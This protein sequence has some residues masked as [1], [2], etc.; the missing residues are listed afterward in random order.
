MTQSHGS[1]LERKYFDGLN[2]L[3][4]VAIIAVI[5]H[6]AERSDALAM[7]DRGFVGVDLFFV[8]SGFLIATLL[9]REKA[10]KGKISLKDF[11]MR[12]VLRLVPVYY[13]LLFGLLAAY[14]VLKPGDPNTEKLIHGFPVYALYLSNWFH[15]GA[16]NLAITWSLATEEQFYLVWP[17]FEAFATPFLTAGFWVAALIV[18]QLINFG[19]LD[20]AIQSVFGADP[21]RYEILDSTFTPIL[22]GVGLAHVLNAERGYSLAIK[23]AGFRYAPYIFGLLLIGLLNIPAGDISGALRLAMHVAMAL[24]LASVIL[25]PRSKLTAMLEWKPVYIIGAVSYGMY[26]YHMWCIHIVRAILAKIGAPQV[27]L[28]FPLALALTVAV[29][30]ASFYLYE[31]RFL[32]LRSKFR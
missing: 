18:N 26:L 12:R 9:I 30:A 28:Q 1:Y 27:W 8:L 15:P 25:Q 10:R 32:N 13:L 22:L 24:W 16:D 11:W 2:G 21:G 5:W 17:L 31:K 14:L 29:S 7:F 19:V 6:H 3:R 23:A 20:P 4:A